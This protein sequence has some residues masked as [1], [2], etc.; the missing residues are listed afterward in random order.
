[1]ISIG[2]YGLENRVFL[3]P[4]A[5]VTDLPFRKLCKSLG[6]GMVTGEMNASVPELRATVRSRL[7]GVHLEEPEPRSIQIVGWCPQMMAEAARFNADQGASIIDINMG[8]PAKKVCRKAAGSALLAY[9]DQVE[10]ILK[11]VV[12]AVD[13]PV[14]LKIR[15]GT[16]RD[17]RNGVQIAKIAED[18]GIRL[19]AVHGRTRADMYKGDAEFETI[20][21]IKM[22]VSIPVI[23]NG[24][25]SSFDGI[26]RVLRYTGCDGVMIGRAA[27]G[28]P[29]FPGQ[30]AG[31]LDTGKIVAAPH[32]IDQHRIVLG[33]LSAIHQFYGPVTGVRIA[34]KHIK[35]YVQS[36]PGSEAFRAKVNLV[37][38][39]SLQ[40]GMVDSFYSEL[41]EQSR[42]A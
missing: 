28:A 8:C 37:N 6:A 15:T 25:M 24:D 29:W 18:A 26:N 17:H 27:H 3:A 42:A 35:W 13:V 36:F 7:R 23:A 38:C 10:A 30:V 11:S 16:D 14:T 4:M 12:D 5:G 9:P 41:Q 1:M 34:R 2:K 33:H 22:A 20:K 39:S 21:D 40:I 19:I 32:I 31:F